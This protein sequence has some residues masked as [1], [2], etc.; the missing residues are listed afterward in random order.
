MRSGSNRSMITSSSG[1]RAEKGVKFGN[2]KNKKG[3]IVYIVILSNV[4]LKLKEE[5]V[6]PPS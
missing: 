2:F 6:F 3:K 1:S 5:E 4:K